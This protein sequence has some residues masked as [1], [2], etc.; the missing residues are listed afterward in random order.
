MGESKG[1]PEYWSEDDGHPRC[2]RIERGQGWGEKRDV[3]RFQDR[4]KNPTRFSS[5]RS[6]KDRGREKMRR[7]ATRRDARRGDPIRSEGEA[8]RDRG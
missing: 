5:A 1:R 4:A 7:D 8:R 6:G 3:F 2:E